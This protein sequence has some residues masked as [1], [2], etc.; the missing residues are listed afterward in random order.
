MFTARDIPEFTFQIRGK[1]CS[2]VALNGCAGCKSDPTSF[3]TVT[4]TE[5]AQPFHG[6]F[7]DPLTLRTYQVL[8]HI[9]T[10]PSLHPEVKHYQSLG[11]VED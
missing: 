7:H 8:N 2:T 6:P 5:Q 4:Y 10:I 11:V 1:Y 9:S 3:C